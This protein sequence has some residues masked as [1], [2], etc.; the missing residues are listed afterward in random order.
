MRYNHDFFTGILGKD[1]FISLSYNMKALYIKHASSMTA[2][3]VEVPATVT[4]MSRYSI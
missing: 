1:K 2:Q 3:L 4:M